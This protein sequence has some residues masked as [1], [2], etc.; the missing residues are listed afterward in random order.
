MSNGWLTCLEIRGNLVDLAPLNM[1]I[2]DDFAKACVKR[3]ILDENDI[4]IGIID[5][6]DTV[7]RYWYGRIVV[8]AAIKDIIYDEYRQSMEVKE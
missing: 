8:N 2:T 1:P 6:V 4:Q 3:P 5:R 7:N